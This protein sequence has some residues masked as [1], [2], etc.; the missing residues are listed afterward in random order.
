MALL[1]RFVG[2]GNRPEHHSLDCLRHS[3][4]FESDAAAGRNQAPK[5]IWLEDDWEIER[6]QRLVSDG[7]MVLL[8]SSAMDE[9]LVQRFPL[10]RRIWNATWPVLETISVVATI[11]GVAVWV[12]SVVG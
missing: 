8:A 1:P 10:I 12:A 9:V 11:T 3:N 2:S 5:R 6:H 4:R 7:T